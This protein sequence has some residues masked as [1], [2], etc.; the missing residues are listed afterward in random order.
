MQVLVDG[1][2]RWLVTIVMVVEHALILVCLL[3]WWWIPS[4]PQAVVD[5]R[6][7]RRFQDA[8]QARE[9]KHAA[10]AKLAQT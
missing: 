7:R 9:A 8:T 4:T 10:R 6:A 5:A 2:G 3:I 1:A